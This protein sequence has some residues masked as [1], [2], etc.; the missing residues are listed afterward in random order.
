MTYQ[1]TSLSLTSARTYYSSARAR[2]RAGNISLVAQ[3]DGWLFTSFCPANYIRV[4]ALSGYTTKD[5]CVAKYEAKAS[6]SKAVS[7]FSGVPSGNINQLESISACRYNGT[8][9]VLDHQ[10]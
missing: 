7:Q 4:P 5:F 6:G 2:D 3:G 1:A 9:Y 8:G 10:C